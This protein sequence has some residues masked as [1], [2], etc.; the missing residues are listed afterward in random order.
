[1]LHG[2]AQCILYSSLIM[3][4]DSTHLYIFSI[5]FMIQPTSAH[6][7]LQGYKCIPPHCLAWRPPRPGGSFLTSPPSR[8]TPTLLWGNI[9]GLQLCWACL[10]SVL[11]P[12]RV[13][14]LRMIP[15]FIARGPLCPLDAGRCW[16]SGA[17][18]G[19]ALPHA[20][21]LASQ[22]PQPWRR[23]LPPHP[24]GRVPGGGFSDAASLRRHQPVLGL[25]LP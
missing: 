23:V 14:L 22:S 4:T 25:L 7:V 15:L 18:A 2:N 19:C 8:P 11:S 16:F 20:A 10:E 24:R 13:S 1:M 3:H 12:M 9:E 17:N 5:T 6:T 21:C